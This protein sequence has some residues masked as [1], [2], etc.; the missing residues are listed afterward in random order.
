MLSSNSKLILWSHFSVRWWTMQAF[1]QCK[2][3]EKKLYFTH[4]LRY[5]LSIKWGHLMFENTKKC[6]GKSM[7]T[8]HRMRSYSSLPHPLD[9]QIWI[10]TLKHM[11]N[12]TE[13]PWNV[14]SFKSFMKYFS[15]V[16]NDFVNW[17][18]STSKWCCKVLTV[19]RVSHVIHSTRSHALMQTEGKRRSERMRSSLCGSFPSFYCSVFFFAFHDILRNKCNKIK[20]EGGGERKVFICTTL[21]TSIHK[22][23]RIIFVITTICENRKYTHK[24]RYTIFFKFFAVVLLR[25]F[26]AIPSQ[27]YLNLFFFCQYLI[28][29]MS[30]KESC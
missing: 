23:T 9:F 24:L 21:S 15:F 25:V 11:S 22:Y 10:S 1:Q 29:E 18:F 3:K 20:G 2:N 14:I 4:I 17:Y 16:N 6:H 28:F 12:P 26:F 19:D 27:L 13:R 5:S 7:P 8:K 30:F